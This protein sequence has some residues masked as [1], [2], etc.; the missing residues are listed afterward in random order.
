MVGT[1]VE[2][3]DNDIVV[4]KFD[5]AAAPFVN[6]S[7]SPSAISTAIS[8]LTT[9]S[10]NV[11]LQ[12]VSPFA[13]NGTN[14]AVQFSGNNSGSPRNYI[15]GA[16]TC[17]PQFPITFS[18]WLYLRTYNSTSATQ[19][20]WSKQHTTGNWSATFAQVGLQ[21][22]TY[23]GQSTAFDI[24][25]TTVTTNNNLILTSDNNI[26]LNTWC[27]IG[28]T[29]DGSN[30]LCYLNGNLIKSATSTGNIN[31]GNSGPWFFGAIPAGSGNPEEGQYSICDFRIANIARP[32]SYFQEIYQKGTL[33]S[34]GQLSVFT[35][36]YKMRAFD[37]YYTKQAVYWTNSEI[38]YNGAPTSPSGWGLGPIEI[39]ETYNVLNV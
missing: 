19:H 31:Y 4:W 10:G 24:F 21:N 38:S 7:T 1:R 8:N 6:S 9:L 13:A 30:K 33:N 15:S 17:E 20:Y 28:L 22:R 5:E 32:Q 26:P 25:A 39:L 11:R 23:T 37:L 27:H 36:F 29:Y 14:S 12:Q 34:D 35:T 2:P 3:D 18:T 16:N